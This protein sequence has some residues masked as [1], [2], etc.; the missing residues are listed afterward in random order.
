MNRRGAVLLTTLAALLLLGAVTAALLLAALQED[1]GARNAEAALVA[2]AAA[3]AALA[4]AASAGDQFV[5]ILAPGESVVVRGSLP[6]ATWEARLRRDGDDMVGVR[7]TG[8]D[9]RQGLRRDLLT[10][11][12][13]V[14]LLPSRRAVAFLRAPPPPS[15]AASILPADST[16]PGWACGP[17]Q[18]DAPTVTD[19]MVPDSVI[20]ALGPLTWP[21]LVS[22]VGRSRSLDSLT[23]HAVPADLTLDGG[24][25]V[26]LLL[27]DGVLTLRGGVE[28]VGVV[29]ARRGLVFGPGGGTLRGTVVAESLGLVSGVTPSAVKLSYSSC[30]S[31]RTGRS[32]APL[33]GLPGL[34]PVDVW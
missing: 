12:R 28:V 10:T 15:L 21:A 4:R 29:V 25:T 19:P 7:G 8:A 13:I 30:A 2:R 32:G 3:G 20:F 1:R 33:R 23:P 24:R 6:G 22:W 17:P 16:P 34:P 14:P 11:L 5:G 18:A 9:G 26:G 27:V 31:G